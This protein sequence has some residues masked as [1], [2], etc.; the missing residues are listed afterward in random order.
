MADSKLIN[1]TADAAPTGDDL[2]Y[3]VNDPAGTP[4]DRKVTITNLAAALAAL[5]AFTDAFQGKDPDLTALAAAQNSAVLAAV[6]EAFTT[7]DGVKL[8]GIEALADVTDAANVASSLAGAWTSYVPAWTATGTAPA[9]GDGTITGA[10]VQFGKTV[11]FRIALTMGASSTYGTGSYKFSLPVAAHAG[12]VPF[13]PLGNAY[14]ED[15]GSGTF[16][17][18]LF[19]FS[20]TTILVG[21]HAILT[22]GGMTFIG[23]TA[24]F[25]WGTAD[26]L[27]LSGTYQAA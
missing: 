5:T 11:H 12:V 15:A 20:S 18:Q 17:G 27:Y 8:D 21:I 25:V 4:V 26:Y 22:A 23:T 24:P 10:Y 7:A 2:L 13:T 16:M 19:D 3:V 6:T 9:V 1:L 14:M